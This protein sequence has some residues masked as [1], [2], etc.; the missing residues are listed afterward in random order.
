MQRLHR[1]G[2]FIIFSAWSSSRSIG[3]MDAPQHV[4]PHGL[5]HRDIIVLSLETACY[6]TMVAGSFV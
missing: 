2:E 5:A 3:Q 1:N 4:H 6:R